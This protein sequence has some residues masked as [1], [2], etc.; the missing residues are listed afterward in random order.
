MARIRN[1]KPEI[2][3]EQCGLIESKSTT[4]ASYILRTI[5]ER[6]VEMQQDLYFCFIEY[7]KAFD[8]VQHV[9]LIHMFEKIN[10]D[11]KDLRI[12]KQMYWEQT[13][14]VK[15]RK[16][17]GQYQKIKRGVRQSYPQTYFHYTVKS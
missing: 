9:E 7:T 3:E 6:S 11:G 10:I 5:I 8:K 1:K 12:I 4:N 17:V 13:A 2:S 15:I 14:A 16:Q